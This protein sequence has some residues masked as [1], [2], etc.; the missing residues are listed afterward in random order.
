MGERI[1]LGQVRTFEDLEQWARDE[2]FATVK[3]IRDGKLSKRVR[4]DP[5]NLA[6][7]LGLPEDSY[8]IVAMSRELEARVKRHVS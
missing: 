7:Q 1:Q 4:F 3:A 2:V 6:K 8:L 5:R